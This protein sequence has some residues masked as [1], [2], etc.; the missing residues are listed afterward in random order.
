MTNEELKKNLI[1]G[2][3]SI[4]GQII[5][6]G[7]EFIGNIVIN[8]QPK[9]LNII[10]INCTFNNDISFTST[11]N[12]PS[13]TFTF[14]TKV[15]FQNCT[16]R[17]ILII[18]NFKSSVSFNSISPNLGLKNCSVN[19][20]EFWGEV[21][22]NN[23]FAIQDNSDIKI[24]QIE[25]FES[26]KSGISITNSK[27]SESFYLG[28]IICKIGEVSF[29]RTEF[30]STSIIREINC[31]QIRLQSFFN[32]EV[33]LYDSEVGS[34]IMSGVFRKDFDIEGLI[35]ETVTI[36][37]SSFEGNLKLKVDHFWN[38]SVPNE[39][40]FYGK[41]DKV[42]LTSCS[43]KS[44]LFFSGDNKVLDVLELKNMGQVFGDLDFQDCKISKL[45][46]SGNNNSL[47]TFNSCAFDN[48]NIEKLVNNSSLNFSVCKAVG[49]E[50]TL[51]IIN[52]DLGKTKFLSFEFSSFK[53][54]WFYSSNLADIIITGVFNI[55]DRKVNPQALP[56][57]LEYREK[58]EVYRLLK[59]ASEKQANRVQALEYKALEMK[60]FRKE[61][62]AGNSWWK[63]L[64][65]LDLFI[66]FLSRSNS[67]GL[68]FFKPISWLIGISLVLFLWIL[69]SL[70]YSLSYIPNLSFESIRFT[71]QK[72]YDN[73]GKY[74]QLL[75]PTA[76]LKVIFDDNP[77]LNGWSHFFHLWFKIAVAYFTFQI[78]SAFRKYV[79]S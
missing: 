42:Q 26:E 9:C 73:L 45:N 2:K 21:V 62:R 37:D 40:K 25:S 32:S 79:K 48:L 35:C 20:I 51:K 50:S 72:I 70:D 69:I 67:Y 74:V 58:R 28:K 43:F 63:R 52:S 56:S 77:I 6:R 60:Y 33:Y 44:G 53:Q 55:E 27:I 15:T 64:R 24:L 14:S 29:F 57:K 16:F 7:D 76:S 65:N 41:I 30:N 49:E 66:L 23:G 59:N 54:L 71:L 1:N 12:D 75:N 78:V 5:I 36:S 46:L 4:N 13:Q 11:F 34:I 61:L 3:G 10:F 39:D 47:I 8:Y 17:K 31:S 22:F 38:A 18:K 68:N 19:K